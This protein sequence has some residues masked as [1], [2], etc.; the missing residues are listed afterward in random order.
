MTFPCLYMLR[1]STSGVLYNSGTFRR[2]RRFLTH[3]ASILE[4]NA[5][6]SGQLD[7]LNVGIKDIFEPEGMSALMQ[8]IDSLKPS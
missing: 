1:V 5:L 6:V 4:A 7:Y 3:D 8:P 2:V